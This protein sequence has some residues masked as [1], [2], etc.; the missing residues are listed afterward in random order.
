MDAIGNPLAVPP[1]VKSNTWSETERGKIQ[2]ELRKARRAK[3][4]KHSWRVVHDTR[5]VV[6]DL[7]ERPF[8]EKVE[9]RSV[10]LLCIACFARKSLPRTCLVCHCDLRLKHDS[11]LCDRCN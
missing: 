4:V 2:D 9:H 5:A 7:A 3:C 1:K 10:T 11:V 8:Y 6:D